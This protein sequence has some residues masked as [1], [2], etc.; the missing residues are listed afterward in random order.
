MPTNGSSSTP[1][2]IAVTHAVTA[3]VLLCLCMFAGIM[4]KVC[5]S[6][7]HQFRLS[8]FIARLSLFIASPHCYVHCARVRP[9]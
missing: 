6:D 5:G 9:N 2:Y 7:A 8:L 3:V 4:L 1:T